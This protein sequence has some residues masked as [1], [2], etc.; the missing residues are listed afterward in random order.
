MSKANIEITNLPLSLPFEP[1]IYENNY[2][3]VPLPGPEWRWLK[4]KHAAE[5]VDVSYRVSPAS[6]RQGLRLTPEPPWRLNALPLPNML[7]SPVLPGTV[8]L[9]PSGLIVLGPDAQ[10]IG[11]YPRVMVLDAEQVARCYQLGIGG[12]VTFRLP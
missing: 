5:L 12:E 2:T 9:T 11:G 1:T 8:Q 7:S 10:T 4:A 3:C 6:S